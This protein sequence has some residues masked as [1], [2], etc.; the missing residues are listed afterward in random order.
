MNKFGKLNTSLDIIPLQGSSNEEKG[1]SLNK[2]RSS[3]EGGRVMRDPLIVSRV[4]AVSI[5]AINNT[6][7]F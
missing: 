7:F 3:E 1:K 2:H 4:Y 5:Y 6:I